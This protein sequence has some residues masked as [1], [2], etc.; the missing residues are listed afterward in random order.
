MQFFSGHSKLVINFPLFLRI[1][2]RIGMLK[3][4]TESYY[5]KPGDSFYCNYVASPEITLSFRKYQLHPLH[6]S[7]TTFYLHIYLRKMIFLFRALSRR[8]KKK[9][10]NISL[11]N[12]L[13]P[14]FYFSIGNYYLFT[15]NKNSIIVES[16]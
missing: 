5:F 15:W 12:G 13:K 3:K 9:R 10:I 14:F 7:F 16:T 2:N 1:T 8:R 11:L 6:L 4:W